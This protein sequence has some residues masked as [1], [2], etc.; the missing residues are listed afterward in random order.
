ME[1]APSKNH[2]K[3][4]DLDRTFLDPWLAEIFFTTQPV[5]YGSPSPYGDKLGQWCLSAWG[6]G[7]SNV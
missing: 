7:I 3:K 1:V 2:G 6:R 4:N 5:P